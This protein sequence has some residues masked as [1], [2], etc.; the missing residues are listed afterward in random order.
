MKRITIRIKRI[1]YAI[2]FLQDMALL[3][4]CLKAVAKSKEIRKS[5]SSSGDWNNIES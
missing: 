2:G 3:K 5:S 4:N 1:R